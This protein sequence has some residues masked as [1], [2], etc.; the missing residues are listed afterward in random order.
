MAHAHL[1]ETLRVLTSSPPSK[2][3]QRI[4]IQ[5]VVRCSGDKQYYAFAKAAR[6]Y[7]ERMDNPA[8]WLQWSRS[9]VA[10]IFKVH[11]ECREFGKAHDIW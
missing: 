4:A 10:A 8:P 2:I 9:F 3:D 5:F 6:G 7:L 1:K 11:L